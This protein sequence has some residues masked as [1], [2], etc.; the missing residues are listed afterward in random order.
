[1]QKIEL[2]IE[3]LVDG[4]LADY[5]K[6]RQIDRMETVRL[7]DKAAVIDMID[8][9]RWIIFPGYS[10]DKNYKVY[11]AKHNLSML[12][13]DV[14]YNLNKQVALALQGAGETEEAAKQRQ[15]RSAFNSSVGSLLSVQWYRQICRLFMRVIRQPQI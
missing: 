4:I 15:R 6:G 3:G 9:L 5:G 7:P 8:K 2:E 11:N 13:E 14:F 1:M 10:K 12:I